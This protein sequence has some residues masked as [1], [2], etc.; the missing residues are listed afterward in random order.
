MNAEISKLLKVIANFVMLEEI[1]IDHTDEI[2]DAMEM[3]GY[4]EDDINSALVLMD[5]IP[6]HSVGTVY[7]GAS[8]SQFSYTMRVAGILT[9]EASNIL[10]MMDRFDILDSY[11]VEEIIDRAEVY[12]NSKGGR[13]DLEEMKGIINNVIL[14]N[15]THGVDDVIRIASEG[16]GAVDH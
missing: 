10:L 4:D 15:V 11:T 12:S 9:M 3:L 1:S 2:F 5:A 6:V 14:E 13:V 8:V 7:G 16:W